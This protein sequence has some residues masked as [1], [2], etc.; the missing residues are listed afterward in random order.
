MCFIYYLWID[1]YRIRLR[2]TLE[3]NYSYITTFGKEFV[4]SGQVIEVR[5]WGS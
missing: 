4:K 2:D 3:G 5:K 1:V